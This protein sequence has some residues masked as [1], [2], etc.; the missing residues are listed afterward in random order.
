MTAD[1]TPLLDREILAELEE[2]GHEF[3]LE[4]ITTFAA[5]ATTLV[6][7]MET[8]I[9][10]GHGNAIHRAAHTMKGSAASVGLARPAA[11]A[12]ELDRVAQVAPLDRVLAGYLLA[13]LA[14]AIGTSLDAV[15][16][17]PEVL[18]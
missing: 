14:R 11:W 4:L 10:A 12:D 9:A 7:Q 5:Q 15:R 18:R 17:E 8:G 13:G 6:D 1:A 2:F 3:V 16:A